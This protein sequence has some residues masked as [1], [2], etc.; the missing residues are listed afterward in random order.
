MLALDGIIQVIE[1][2][3][4]TYHEMLSLLPLNSHP[5]PEKVSNYVLSTQHRD[6][7]STFVTF[8]CLCCSARLC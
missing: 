8:L 4:F 6:V 2:D 3:E 7:T 5:N 1:R